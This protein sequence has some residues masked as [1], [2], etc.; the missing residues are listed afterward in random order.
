MVTV[1]SNCAVMVG[2]AA[3]LINVWLLVSSAVTVTANGLLS[4]CGEGMVLTVNEASGG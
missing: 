1:G 2:A 3:R 4:S